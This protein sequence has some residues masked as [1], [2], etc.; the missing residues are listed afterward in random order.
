M[1]LSNENALA[2]MLDIH[3]NIDEYSELTVKNIIENKILPFLRI[4]EIAVSQT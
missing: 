1:K 2:L 4:H 3:Q